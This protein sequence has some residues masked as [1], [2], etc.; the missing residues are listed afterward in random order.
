MEFCQEFIHSHAVVLCTLDSMGQ[1]LVSTCPD[2]WRTPLRGLRQI[3]WHRTNKEWQ[4][5]A[6]SDQDVINRRQNRMECGIIP[7]A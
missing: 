4:S 6:M 3:D 2:D 5:V 7:E 1:T